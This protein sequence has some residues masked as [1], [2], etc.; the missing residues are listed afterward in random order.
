MKINIITVYDQYGK[1]LVECRGVEFCNVGQAGNLFIDM[2]KEYG[3]VVYA[4]GFWSRY[5]FQTVDE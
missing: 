5:T 1:V 2:G 3:A 4:A